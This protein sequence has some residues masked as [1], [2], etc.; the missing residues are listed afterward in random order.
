M[1]L[2]GTISGDGTLD[3]TPD[4]E[5]D[6]PAASGPVHYSIDVFQDERTSTKWASGTATGEDDLLMAAWYDA[7]GCVLHLQ[8][9]D[10]ILVSFGW[11]TIGEADFD[12]KTA[13][14]G[15]DAYG[16]GWLYTD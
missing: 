14:P 15:F 12:V 11:R 9:G 8:S 1:Q 10:K 5:L 13:V 3:L 7:R 4:R 16:G 6:I 2:L